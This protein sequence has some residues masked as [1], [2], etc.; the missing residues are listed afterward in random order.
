[1]TSLDRSLSLLAPV[2]DDELVDAVRSPQAA[3]L[4]AAIIATPVLRAAPRAR[5]RLLV[6]GTAIAVAVALAA[7]ALGVVGQVRSWLAGAHG[8]D[9]PVPTRPDVVIASGV[10]GIPWTIVATP[11]DRGLCLFLV[12]RLHGQQ[13]GGGGCG[14][15]DIRG[16]L[17][18]DVRGDPG[19]KCLAAPTKVVPCGSLP[20][21][22]LDVSLGGRDSSAFAGSIVF[23]LAAADVASVK[24]FLTDGRTLRPRLVE[25]PAL[26]AP[27]KFYW[28]TWN[29]DATVELGIARGAAGRVLERRVPAWNGNPTGDPDGPTA[30]G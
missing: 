27:L 1:V 3:A 14:Y 25:A 8:P 16:A 26:G 22:R 11:S 28:A 24:L 17:P 7:A 12:T 19:Q 29:G 2:R 6:A 4:L 13:D 5:L 23:S 30:P 9:A 20:R 21:H 18:P 15:V 10:A